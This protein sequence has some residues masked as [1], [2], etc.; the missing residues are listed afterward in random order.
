MRSILSKNNV[1]SP[2]IDCQMVDWT[3]T[4]DILMV[5]DDSGTIKLEGRILCG[6]GHLRV[7]TRGCAQS[8]RP[9]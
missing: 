3:M 9:A 2:K 8:D 7:A 6:V 4:S 1:E 5:H